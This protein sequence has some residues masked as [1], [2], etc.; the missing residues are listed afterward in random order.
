MR[1][2]G[3]KISLQRVFVLCDGT[4]QQ[5]WKGIVDIVDIC[6]RQQKWEGIDDIVDIC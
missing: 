5:K 1:L 2:S 6:N 4:V 3:I